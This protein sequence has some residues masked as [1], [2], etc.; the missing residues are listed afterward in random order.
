MLRT[1][2]EYIPGGGIYSLE[3][4]FS[5]SLYI[6]THPKGFAPCYRPLV[7]GSWLPGLLD[8]FLNLVSVVDAWTF[9]AKPLGTSRWLWITFWRP[10]ALP[11]DIGYD[12]GCQ[13][14]LNLLL[15][16]GAPFCSRPGCQ[17]VGVRDP[18]SF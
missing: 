3:C 7:S 1:L 18:K 10:E 5:L 11:N 9:I 13:D 14:M 2:A 8:V 12:F 15:S 17:T 6:Y 16:A 4:I